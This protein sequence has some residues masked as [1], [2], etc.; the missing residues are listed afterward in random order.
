MV[1][2]NLAQRAAHHEEGASG[3]CCTDAQETGLAGCRFRLGGVTLEV[4]VPA[5]L[6]AAT[7][8]GDE[9]ESQGKPC[10]GQKASIEHV[11]SPALPAMKRN[12]W[13]P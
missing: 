13:A 9:A 3:R 6:A 12:R 1:V 2:Q 7:A 8:C 5:R 4:T 10:M 11:P